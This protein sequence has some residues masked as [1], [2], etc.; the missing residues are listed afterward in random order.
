MSDENISADFPFDSKFVEV[1]GSKI[2]YVEEGK[3]DPVLFIHGNPAWSYTWRNVIPHVSPHARAIAVDLIGFGKSDKPDID[4]GFGDS[5][6]YLEGFIEQ[7]GLKNVTL[8]VQDWGS[9]LGFHY[10]NLHRDNIKAIAF[11]E[12][13]HKPINFDAL[14]SGD[15]FMMRMIRSKPFSWLMLGAMNMFVKQMLPDWVKRDLSEVEM[16]QY[17]APF[18][19]L[20]SRKPIHVFPRDVP[21]K[22]EPE[23]SAA[24]V[25]NYHKWLTQTQIPKLLFYADPGVLIRP[26]DAQ[27]IMRNFPNTKAVDLGEGLHFVQEDYPHTIGRELAKWYIEIEKGTQNVK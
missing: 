9:G 1:N 22:G 4:Y 12:A 18:R 16:A 7:L 14:A 23:H 20:K 2:H 27:W 11:M 6:A 19:T 8:V 13:M 3:G 17:L 25:A 24:A 26:D 10:A 5:Y 15:K 21:V